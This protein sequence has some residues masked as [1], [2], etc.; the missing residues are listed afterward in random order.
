[1]H[2][3]VVLIINWHHIIVVTSKLQ[4]KATDILDFKPLWCD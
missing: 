3:E 1:M 2:I 4:N